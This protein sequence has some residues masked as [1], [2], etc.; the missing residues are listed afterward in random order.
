[1][2][3]SL[4][5][6]TREQLN[7]DLPFHIDVLR[8]SRGEVVMRMAREDAGVGG[9]G[10]VFHNGVIP[11]L[12]DTAG[13][14]AV[15]TQMSWDQ[16]PGGTADIHISYSRPAVGPFVLATAR[17]RK[18]GSS[19]SVADVDITDEKQRLC[20]TGVLT[21]SVRS[22][23]PPS[24]PPPRGGADGGRGGGDSRGGAGGSGVGGNGG[25]VGKSRDSTEAREPPAPAGSP[26][27]V[28]S[29]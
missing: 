15:C 18:A 9:V 24:L 3:A 8:I 13:A 22:G 29:F 2:W 21:Y 14:A 12:F 7:L 23:P 28:Y 4:Q 1:M 26:L 27:D 10:G 11:I 19:L 5:S 25:D 17:A 20:A 16:Y 6:L